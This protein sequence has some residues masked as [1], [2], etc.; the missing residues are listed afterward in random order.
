MA[1]KRKSLMD[2]TESLIMKLV[3][4]AKVPG[5]DIPDRVKAADAALRFLLIQNKLDPESEESEFERDLRAAE[6]A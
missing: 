1:S 2:E 5:T 3:K 6:Q 4:D